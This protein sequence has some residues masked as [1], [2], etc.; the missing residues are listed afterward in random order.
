MT[1][2]NQVLLVVDD[3]QAIVNLIMEFVKMWGINAVSANSADQAW[4]IFSNQPITAILSDIDMPGKSG[5]DLLKQVR[6]TGSEVPFT[7]LTAHDTKGNMIKSIQYGA[8]H[9]IEK[10]FESSKLKSTILKIMELGR[11]IEEKNPNRKIQN[12]LRICIGDS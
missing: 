10:P 8:T 6:A 9:F 7:F 3:E 2:D 1:D 4:E 12:L 5:I 11:R